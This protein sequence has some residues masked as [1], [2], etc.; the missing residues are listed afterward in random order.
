[1]A[2]SG[3][4]DSAILAYSINKYTNKKIDSCSIIFENENKYN[5]IENIKIL[6]KKFK[7]F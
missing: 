1:M 5:E 4:I 7:K 2:L 6:E 3:G